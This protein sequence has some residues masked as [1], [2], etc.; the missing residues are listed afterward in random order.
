VDDDYPQFYI[1]QPG[2]SAAR[3][4]QA[5]DILLWDTDSDDSDDDPQAPAPFTQEYKVYQRRK[6]L[7]QPQ[8]PSP[9]ASAVLATAVTCSPDKTITQPCSGGGGGGGGGG[10]SSRATPGYDSGY[11]GDGYTTAGYTTDS[12]SRATGKHYDAIDYT[13]RDD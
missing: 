12:G 13:D 11:D 9:A 4:P 8:Q 10:C 3:P 1:L 5:T 6:R 7:L 2:V